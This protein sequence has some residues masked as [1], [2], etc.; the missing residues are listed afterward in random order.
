[1]TRPFIS[2]EYDA[3]TQSDL[4]SGSTRADFL[5]FWSTIEGFASIRHTENG[6]WFIQ[7][8]VKKIQELH[9]NQHLMDICT[10]VTNEVSSK[11][12]YKDEC[13]VPK[14]ESTFIK[15][16]RFPPVSNEN[17]LNDS[18]TSVA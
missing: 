1:V 5:L 11:R 12:G 6:S 3:P 4:I 7:E 17:S 8:F 15:I 13:M 2:Y 16:F 9:D 18:N 10:A 14:L